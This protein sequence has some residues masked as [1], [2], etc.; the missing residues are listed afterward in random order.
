MK[1]FT[2]LLS[3]LLFGLCASAQ[4]LKLSVVND[5][6]EPLPYAYIYVN[7]R[8]AV[9]T[10][11]TGQA[12]LSEERLSPGDTLC[13]TY[14]GTESAWII[15]DQQ[16]KAHGTHPFILPEIY[17]SL[18]A[19]EVT[20]R[21]DIVDL[22]RKHLRHSFSIFYNNR[23][24]AP[25]TW[26]N[27]A[28]ETRCEIHGE[29]TAEMKGIENPNTGMIPKFYQKPLKI[30]TAQDTTQLS[31]RIQADIVHSLELMRYWN[32]LFNSIKFGPQKFRA[33]AKGWKLAYRGRKGGDH[34]FRLSDP[35]EDGTAQCLAFVSE[36]SKRIRR[37][38]W[39]SYVPSR[40]GRPGSRSITS[41]TPIN[42]RFPNC[43]AGKTSP[44]SGP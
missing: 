16:L 19:E 33:N 40:S 8:V 22:L 42:G 18:T 25:F 23:L 24:R 20:V 31:E 30:A 43:Y 29:F 2:L 11:S 39:H 5:R 1:R 9:V 41:F 13:A 14:I 17:P 32:S 12:W 10:D 7:G 34:I 38:E 26:K 36:E 37:I 35:Q 6:N 44:Y 27:D 4:S 28:A 21:I 3:G 15:F